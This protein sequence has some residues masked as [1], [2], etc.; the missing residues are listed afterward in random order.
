MNRTLFMFFLT[1]MVGSAA[2]VTYAFASPP[3]YRYQLPE[4]MVPHFANPDFEN[5]SQILAWMDENL[6]YRLD[7]PDNRDYWQTPSETLLKGGGDCEDLSLLFMYL[8]EEELGVSSSLLLVRVDGREDIGHAI[9][10]AGGQWFEMTVS[11]AVHYRGRYD[12]AYK[13]S[14]GK[15]LHTAENYHSWKPLRLFPQPF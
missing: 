7:G 10:E 9:V 11:K 12:V 1:L 13:L 14:Y 5:V 6:E 3:G 4:D 8:L 15:S 2:L